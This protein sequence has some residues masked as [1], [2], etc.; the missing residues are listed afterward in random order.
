MQTIITNAMKPSR[1]NM[2]HHPPDERQRRDLFLRTLLGLVIVV[3]IPRP[4][5]VVAQDAPQGDR[6]ADD[7]FRQVIC[8][9]LATSRDLALF[10]IGDQASGIRAPQSVDL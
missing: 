5:P 9:P 8:Q 2:L 3:P 1:Q 10:S 7:V 6:G 4:L